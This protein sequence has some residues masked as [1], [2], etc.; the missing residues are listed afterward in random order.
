MYEKGA[1]RGFLPVI[2]HTCMRRGVRVFPRDWPYMYE[3]GE[4]GVILP[5]MGDV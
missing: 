3:K 1:R 2:G 4:G 5:V